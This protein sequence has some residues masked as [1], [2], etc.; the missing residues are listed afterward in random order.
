MGFSV[1]T[2]YENELSK[3]I[4]V[5][6]IRKEIKEIISLLGGIKNTSIKSGVKYSLLKEWPLGRKPISIF[7]LN[8]LL[9][10]LDLNA[11]QKILNNLSNEDIELGCSYSHIKMKFPKTLTSDLSYLIGLILGDGSL[12]GDGSNSKGN[13]KIS[14]AFDNEIHMNYCIAL[15]KSI[16]GIQMKYFRRGNGHY[17]HCNSKA[18]HWFLKNYFEI[19][20]GY[21][22]EKIFTPLLIKCADIFCKVAFIQGLFDSD[23]TITGK[24]IKY[25]T[26]SERMAKE[27]KDTLEDFG[28]KTYL[29]T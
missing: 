23:G 22:A 1:L 20:N 6:G 12:S 27:V 11:A 2:Y 16:F 4:Y 10:F 26:I 25:A 24:T 5:H 28:L 9:T 7:S 13:W 29:Y 15:I 17:C 14:L 21:K 18:L 8:K 19:S 3:Q